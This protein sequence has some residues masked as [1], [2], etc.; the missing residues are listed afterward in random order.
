ML[1]VGLCVLRH[2]WDSVYCVI[3]GTLCLVTYLNSVINLVEL[4]A[5]CHLLDSVHCVICWILCIVLSVGL[6]VL[7]HLWNSVSCDISGTL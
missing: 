2:L 3:C 5:L 6:C 1:S 7:R 4:C